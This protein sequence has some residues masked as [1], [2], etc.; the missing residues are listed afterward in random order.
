MP[1]TFFMQETTRMSL[2]YYYNNLTDNRP[3]ADP[4]LLCI[5][6]G[7]D[8]VILDQKQIITKL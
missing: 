4:H 2:D 6:R 5:P 7:K 8:F 3:S 1:N